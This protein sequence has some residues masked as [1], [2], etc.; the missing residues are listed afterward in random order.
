MIQE[1]Q[2]AL[3]TATTVLGDVPWHYVGQHGFPH[4][5]F[6][7]RTFVLA[8]WLG[9]RDRASPRPRVVQQLRFSLDASDP[10]V[11]PE[12]ASLFAVDLPV[13]RT[14]HG[15]PEGSGLVFRHGALQLTG[16]LASEDQLYSVHCL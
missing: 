3:S 15:Q 13:L 16:S 12:L 1:P 4:T 11:L 6:V 9:A 10:R 5:V 8:E 14:L 2:P 7:F